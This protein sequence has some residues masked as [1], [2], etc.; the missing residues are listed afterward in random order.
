MFRFITSTLAF[1]MIVGCAVVNDVS[2]QELKEVEYTKSIRGTNCEWDKEGQSALIVAANED[3]YKALVGYVNRAN[4][5]DPYNF[6]AFDKDTVYLLICGGS[7]KETP[8]WQITV[9]QVKHTRP[10]SK[11][12]ATNGT[13]MVAVTLEP[14]KEK[15]GDAATSNW[16]LLKV[17]KTAVGWNEKATPLTGKL[18]EKRV[19]I[20]YGE[21]D[22]I[23]PSASRKP[24]SKK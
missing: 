21:S 20:T 4:K 14:A 7:L 12:V 2:G 24:P 16:L 6:P 13:I 23:N 22:S 3:Q 1:A 5:G 8:G 10:K 17:D 15:T 11:V 19:T 18:V 9:D